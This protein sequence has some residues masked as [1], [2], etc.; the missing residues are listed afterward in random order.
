MLI[1]KHHSTD[2]I[3]NLAAIVLKFNSDLNATFA[4]LR[5]TFAQLETVTKERDNFKRL[6]D[7]LTEKLSQVQASLD[8]IRN[9]DTIELEDPSVSQSTSFSVC[10]SDSS[11]SDPP[12]IPG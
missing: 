7:A 4:Q 12:P 10:P 2:D 1:D 6:A 8:K 11:E 5:E 9:P 3:A